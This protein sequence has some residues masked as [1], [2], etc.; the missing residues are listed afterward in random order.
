MN[1]SLVFNIIEIRLEYPTFYRTVNIQNKIEGLNKTANRPQC[2]TD[3]MNEI[4]ILNNIVPPTC[5]WR[6]ISFELVLSFVFYCRIQKIKV[7]RLSYLVVYIKIYVYINH[8]PIVHL[9]RLWNMTVSLTL[10]IAIVFNF[11]LFMCFWIPSF[12][13]HQ[14][15]FQYCTRLGSI[16]LILY[17]TSIL[18]IKSELH[19]RSLAPLSNSSNYLKGDNI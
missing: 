4:E 18:F 9:N 3:F 10:N 19:C 13:S 8:M 15:G 17:R 11:I 6:S 7:L 5:P 1:K 12:M 14:S 16:I 2:N